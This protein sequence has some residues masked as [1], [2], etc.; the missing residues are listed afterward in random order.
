MAELP[1]NNAVDPW[2]VW[3]KRQC[4]KWLDETDDNKVL[5]IQLYDVTYGSDRDNS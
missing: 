4:D 3:I 5:L 1:K 2:F